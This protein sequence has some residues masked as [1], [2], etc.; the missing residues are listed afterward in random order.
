MF[1]LPWV[2]RLIFV[3]LTLVVGAAVRAAE[4]TRS[5]TRA[6]LVMG[7]I[8]QITIP[9]GASN[10]A[11]EV[12]FAAL[13]NVDASMSLYRPE[14]A[15]V[16]VNAHAALHAEPVDAELFACLERACALSA[17]TDGAFDVTVL[18]L[19][20]AWGAYPG[21][22]YLASGRLDAV[23]WG[24]ILLDPAAREVRFRREGMG[25]DLG[26]IAKGFA[27]DRARAALADS[28]VRRAVLDLGGNL[29]FLGDGPGPG[30]RVAVRD[31]ADPE[32][33]L[34]V[35]VLDPGQTVST[36]GNYNRD[37]A[38]EGWRARSHIYDPRTGRPVRENLA[39]TVWAPDATT[40]DA[41]STALLVLGPDGAG[42][43]LAREPDVG[44][45][46]VDDGGNDRRIILMGRSPRGFE[47]RTKGLH[48]T[49][50]AEQ[51]ESARW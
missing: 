3:M 50:N 45:L 14:S 18:P 44:S 21:L 28:G 31:P 9:D 49:T 27:L 11:F 17:M 30:W 1:E 4:P 35:L 32:T 8:A 22:D 42:D 34:G 6:E 39:V 10:A 19:L 47:S 33:S 2:C 41:L 29:A 40:A 13:R 38:V 51:T 43:V 25:I 20:R 26:G 15:L 48:A 7:S 24:G 23:G 12:A 36:S 5:S 46:F 16:R 37:F